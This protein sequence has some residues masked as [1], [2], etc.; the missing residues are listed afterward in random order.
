MRQLEQALTGI[1][2]A[3]TGILLAGLVTGPGMI[4]ALAI[5]FIGGFTILGGPR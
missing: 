5:A 3:F 1:A 2:I 4:L